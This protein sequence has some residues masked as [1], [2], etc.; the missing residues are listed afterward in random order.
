MGK[1]LDADTVMWRVYII[2]AVGTVLWAAVVLTLI[3]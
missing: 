3:L 2:T 1:D